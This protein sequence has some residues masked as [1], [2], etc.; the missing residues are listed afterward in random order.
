MRNILHILAAILFFT[1]C[2][3][4]GNKIESGNNNANDAGKYASRLE[5]PALDNRD[6]FITHTTNNNNKE[7]ITYSIAH[8]AER[9]HCRWV[10]FTFDNSN[11]GE[12]WYR[13]KWNEF[14][15]SNEWVKKELEASGGYCSDPYQPTPEIPQE[16]QHTRNEII[17]NGH[18]RGHIVAS[19]DR[20]YSKEANEQT[21]YYSNISPMLSKFNS[22]VWANLEDKVK[23]WGR[24]TAFSDTLYIV[25]GGTIESG[26]YTSDY[27]RK[28]IPS[29]YFMA[30]MSVRKGIYNTIGFFLEHKANNDSDIMKYALTIDELESKTGIDFFCNLTDIT[31]ENIER[32]YD[33]NKWR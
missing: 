24:N 26:Y 13:S 33:K 17:G 20:L 10:A 15:N 27:E 29:Y 28:T 30:L 22:G 32:V 4:T 19:S 7:C 5:I 6:I 23:K 18:V 12:N 14:A 8:N 31:E 1:S 2:H 25:K 11:R 3:N 21:F 9:K 16:Y